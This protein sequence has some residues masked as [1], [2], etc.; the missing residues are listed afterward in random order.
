M[1]AT[2]NETTRTWCAA[3]ICGIL[4]LLCLSGITRAQQ[5]HEFIYMARNSALMDA[6]GVAVG[7]DG[8]IFLANAEGAI[9]MYCCDGMDLACMGEVCGMGSPGNIAIRRD[10]TVFVTCGGSVLA[11]RCED[12]TLCCSARLTDCP[13]AEDVAVG[14]DGTVFVA[15]KKDGIRAYQCE[16]NAFIPAGRINDIPSSGSVRSIEVMRDGT[17]ILATERDGLRAYTYIG[18]SFT[19]VASLAVTGDIRGMDIGED[20][21]MYLAQGNSGVHV[22]RIEGGEFHDFA[23]EYHNVFVSDVAVGPDGVIYASADDGL[24]AYAY[25]HPALTLLATAAEETPANA[26]SVHPDNTVFLACGT[27][28]L[29]RY[30]L[31]GSEFIGIAH[32]DDNIAYP[33]EAREVQIAADGSIFLANGSDGIHAYELTGGILRQTAHTIDNGSVLSIG[34]GLDSSIWIGNDENELSQYGYDGDTLAFWGEFGHIG[35]DPDAHVTDFLFPDRERVIVSTSAG[36]LILIM[37]VGGMPWDI[38]DAKPGRTISALAQGPDGEII[39]AG[40][41]GIVAY[42]IVENDFE[43]VASTKDGVAAESVAVGPDGTIFALRDFGTLYAYEMDGDS[44]HCTAVMEQPTEPYS[45][46]THVTVGPDGTIFSTGMAGTCAY[47][48]TGDSFIRTAELQGSSAGIAVG[49]DGTVFLPMRDAGMY[50]YS[51]TAT[52]TRVPRIS[53]HPLALDFG[54]VLVDHSRRQTLS[55][56]NTG[57]AALEFHVEMMSGADAE[58]FRFSATLPDDIPVSSEIELGVVCYPLSGGAKRA[59]VQ[60]GTND[61]DNPLIEIP[62]TAHAEIVP[63]RDELRPSP[64]GIAP[65]QDLLLAPPGFQGQW[66]PQVTDPLPPN[67]YVASIDAVSRNVVWAIADTTHLRGPAVGQPRILRTTDGGDTWEMRTIPRTGAKFLIDITAL[68]EHTAWVT[69]N[70][71]HLGDGGIFK[72]TDGGLTWSEQL[73]RNACAYIHFFDANDGLHVN[74]SIVHYTTDGGARWQTVDSEHYPALLSREFMLYYASNNSMEVIGDDVWIGTSRG[75]VY[76]STDRGRHWTAMQT[77]LPSDAAITSVAFRDRQNGIAVSCLENERFKPTATRMI[78]TRDGGQTWE[79]IADPPLR[80][81][82]TCIEYVPGTASTYMMAAMDIDDQVPGTAY[83][84]NDGTTWQLIDKNSHNSV[85]FVDPSTGWTSCETT[86]DHCTGFIQKWA[87]APL[88]AATAAPALPPG[89]PVLEK[90]YPQPASSQTFIPFV[91]PR[92]GIVRLAVYDLL[93]RRALL[94]ADRLY[95]AGRHT[96]QADLAALRPGVY[97]YRLESEGIILSRKF[98][99]LH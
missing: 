63:V 34:I 40:S 38:A 37:S 26:V 94:L 67:Y 71:L 78:R 97:I 45:I 88:S 95:E 89:S 90:N 23:S 4:A 27:H 52:S 6:H 65:R 39:T 76:H 42:R 68:D 61:P 11:L 32:V 2:N 69:M 31:R 86:E 21:T 18:N 72:T 28:G 98:T 43:E 19:L 60:I 58:D 91:L 30:A 5:S 36:E 87:G 55:I 70:D 22:Y 16:M 14:P 79:S 75:R 66:L 46:E 10:G 80:P 20:G 51:Y 92:A 47:T 77:S 29:H 12:S 96:L 54:D 35:S 85:A 73:K 48:Y 83:S 17:V 15:C 50:V 62:L 9:R 99:V 24:H 7:P 33:G 53:V 74:R 81:S 57:T 56:R 49:P 44:L 3:C 84:T 1:T 8:R 64:D 25:D 59:S 13:S 82:G 41:A 93:G